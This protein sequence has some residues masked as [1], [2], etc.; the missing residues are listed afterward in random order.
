MIWMPWCC[1]MT[2]G[3]TTQRL[4]PATHRSPPDRWMMCHGSAEVTA[5]AIW[6]TMPTGRRQTPWVNFRAN[7]ISDGPSD[8]NAIWARSRPAWWPR[9]PSLRPSPWFCCRGCRSCR[10]ALNSCDVRPNV[11]DFWLPWRSNWCCWRWAAGP[12]FGDRRGPPC[13]ASFSS[14][15]WSCCSFSSPRSLTACFTASESL[16]N[17][18]N[19]ITR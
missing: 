3:E 2:D 10:S 12:S 8:A 18:T 11:K 16:N 5:T 6:P 4:S 19:L 1:R 7:R 17:R 14:A 13:R 15:H 9:W